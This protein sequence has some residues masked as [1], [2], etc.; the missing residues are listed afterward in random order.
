[1]RTDHLR[2]AMSLAQR[3]KQLREAGA[4]EAR[5][6][7]RLLF[8]IARSIPGAS[9]AGQLVQPDCVF[10]AAH[11]ELAILEGVDLAERRAAAARLASGGIQHRLWGHP[12]LID[13]T[14][15]GRAIR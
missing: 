4:G 14:A 7:E 6:I 10:E 3:L 2:V 9:E 15:A 12:V 13:T 8:P 1:M 5:N 11:A